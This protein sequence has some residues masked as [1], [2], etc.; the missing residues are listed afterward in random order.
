MNNNEMIMLIVAFIVGF[1]IRGL[2]KMMCQSRLVEGKYHGGNIFGYDDDGT[3]VL[4]G[5]AT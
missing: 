4:F 2:M 1:M 5:I 3:W